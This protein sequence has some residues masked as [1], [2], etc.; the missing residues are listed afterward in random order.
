MPKAKF[1]QQVKDCV[2]NFHIKNLSSFFLFI[3]YFFKLD[4]LKGDGTL[5]RPNGNN[6]S[7]DCAQ[8]LDPG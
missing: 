8:A 6:L 5:L 7:S 1:Y 3:Y 4:G 2:V